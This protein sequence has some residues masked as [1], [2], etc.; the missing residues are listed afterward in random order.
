LGAS[1]GFLLLGF[2]LYVGCVALLADYTSWALAFGSASSVVLVLAGT[3]AFEQQTS[4][5]SLAKGATLCSFVLM[6]VVV[7]TATVGGLETQSGM[8]RSLALVIFLGGI[9]PFT[10]EVL[11][12]RH[13][14][15]SLSRWTGM[16]R[17]LVMSTFFFTLAHFGYL[18]TSV[19]FIALAF[20][21]L[22]FACMYLLTQRLWISVVLHGAWNISM[23]FVKQPPDYTSARK[24]GLD[25]DIGMETQL[26]VVVIANFSL[27]VLC[28]VVCLLTYLRRNRIRGSLLNDAAN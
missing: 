28:A 5:R 3:P 2:A 27:V 17:G 8:I 26:I 24:F 22:V 10:E 7:F 16:T 18:G 14:Q 11:F 9:V 20:M 23:M 21:G 13:L 1:K 4:A 15:I 25:I 6:L 19:N 12:R